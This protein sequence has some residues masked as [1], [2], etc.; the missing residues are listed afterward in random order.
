[1]GKGIRV[2]DDNMA[3]LTLIQKSDGG[4]FLKTVEE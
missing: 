3:L 1:L 2:T 4:D